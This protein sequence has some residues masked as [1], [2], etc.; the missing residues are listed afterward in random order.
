MW[1]TLFTLTLVAALGLGTAAVVLQPKSARITPTL[2]SA[3]GS[4]L[5]LLQRMKALDLDP[6]RVSVSEPLLFRRLETQCRGCESKEPCARDLAERSNDET[7][8]EWQEYCPN[9]STLNM[10]SALQVSAPR[11][12]HAAAE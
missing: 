1:L 2:R 3:S 5:L 10:L 9:G 4:D 11:P 6:A 7:R 8:W 12:D